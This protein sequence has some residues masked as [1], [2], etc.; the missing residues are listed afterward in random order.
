[1]S[2]EPAPYTN[3]EHHD[4][5]EFQ[6]DRLILFTDAVFAIAITLLA[7]E[8]RVPE[9]PHLSERAAGEGLLNL[10]PKFM[11]FLVGFFVIAAY[12]VAHHRLFRFV[13]HYDDRLLWLNIFFL[14]GIVLMPFTSGYF[15]EYILLDVPY[16][17]YAGSVI[18][19][20]LLQ[21]RMQQA[22]RDPRRGY[23]HPNDL[24]HPDLDLLRPLLVVAVFILAIALTLTF[25]H[26]QWTRAAATLIF[27]CFVL[28]GRRYR[29]LR[30][31]WQPAVAAPEAEA[32]G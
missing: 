12:W 15:S 13:R 24:G 31:Q 25:P 22:L 7:I 30:Q 18:L 26:Q 9:L 11:G 6:V 1:M 19:T 2:D 17:A 10:L 20:G 16:L 8:L 29:R 4:R 3:L 27:P 28:Y 32:V 5:I 14:L 21:M 23:L